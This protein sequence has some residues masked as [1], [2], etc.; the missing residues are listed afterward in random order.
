MSFISV[1]YL[2]C[3]GGMGKAHFV[4]SLAVHATGRQDMPPNAE[5]TWSMNR[6]R[7]HVANNA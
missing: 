2:H 5:P 6:I 1:Y 4:H 3:P 7:M